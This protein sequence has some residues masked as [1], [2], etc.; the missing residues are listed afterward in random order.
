[1]QHVN[2]Y[3]YFIDIKFCLPSVAVDVNLM[4]DRHWNRKSPA[5]R[6]C[7][8][9]H[10]GDV[11]KAAK[12]TKFLQQ[13]PLYILIMSSLFSTVDI[14]N[15]A[16]LSIFYSLAESQQRSFFLLL[17]I[18]SANGKVVDCF[19]K[20]CRSFRFRSIAPWPLSI[21]PSSLRYLN[22]LLITVKLPYCTV[23]ERRSRSCLDDLDNF[24]AAG[25]TPAIASATFLTSSTLIN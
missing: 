18:L 5:D 3:V 4:D 1:M 2:H 14:N 17:K 20:Q 8:F 13:L 15:S 22:Y 11:E 16:K 7:W 24:H 23:F 12:Q 10:G 21:E 19:V 25:R 6:C 9:K